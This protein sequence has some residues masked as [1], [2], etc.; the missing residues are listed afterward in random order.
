[1]G[2]ISVSR[3]AVVTIIIVALFSPVIAQPCNPAIDGTY[4]ASQ[5]NPRLSRT[6]GSARANPSFGGGDFFSIVQENNP[7]T[8]GAITFQSDGT[9]CVGLLRRSRCN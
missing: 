4:C 9:R 7:A 1:M 5:S 2:G 3:T 6:Q 8:L